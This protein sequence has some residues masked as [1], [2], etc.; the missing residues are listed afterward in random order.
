VPNCRAIRDAER[1]LLKVNLENGISVTSTPSQPFKVL[2]RN[3]E[4]E[5]KQAKDL[6]PGD[7]IVMR[8][9]YPDNLPM[10]NYPT[11][12]AAERTQ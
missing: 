4:Y 7:S 8:L 12:R 10:S 2:N 3:L 5:W 6:A 9:E 1:D 11:G